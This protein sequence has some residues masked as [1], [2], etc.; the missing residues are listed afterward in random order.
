[1]FNF[2]T[3]H[4]FSIVLGIYPDKKCSYTTT[5]KGGGLLLCRYHPKLPLFYGRH[6]ACFFRIIVSFFAS[7]YSLK[8]SYIVYVYVHL[9]HGLA[10]YCIFDIFLQRKKRRHWERL[11]C[12]CCT[13]DG[14]LSRLV[15]ASILPL[16]PASSVRFFWV[17]IFSDF[18][19][20]WIR[21]NI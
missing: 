15:K 8:T 6:F 7:I 16:G 5:S 4:L 14:R 9:Y 17:W 12:V 19:V 20:F 2:G 3:N 11:K 10:C 1:M 13:I 18:S 21:K